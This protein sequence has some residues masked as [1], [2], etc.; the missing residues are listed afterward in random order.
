[1]QAALDFTRVSGESIKQAR[2]LLNR[3]I[4]IQKHSWQRDSLLHYPLKKRRQEKCFFLSNFYTSMY[5]FV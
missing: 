3:S 5:L 4:T 1:M 2:L